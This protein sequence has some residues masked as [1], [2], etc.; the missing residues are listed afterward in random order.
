MEAEQTVTF[1]TH[2][3]ISNSLNE[4]EFKKKKTLKPSHQTDLWLENILNNLN[5]VARRVISHIQCLTLRQRGGKI[6][7]CLLF[8]FNLSFF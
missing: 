2:L 5:V 7:E 1:N 8:L 4:T 3:L 6:R